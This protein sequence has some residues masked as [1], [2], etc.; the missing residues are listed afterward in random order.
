[1]QGEFRGDFTR[2][3]ASPDKSFLRVLMQAGRV[4]IDADWNEQV[5]NLLRYIQGLGQ[6]LIGFHGGREESFLIQPI[7]GNTDDFAITPGRYYVDGIPCE[8]KARQDP[9]GNFQNWTYN[10]QPYYSISEN[11]SL[12]QLHKGN[13][14]IALLVYL[15]MWER[16]ISFVEDY[17]P[18]NPGIRE[19]A[20]GGPDTATRSQVVWQIKVLPAQPVD[21]VLDEPSFEGDVPD[22][23]NGQTPLEILSMQMRLLTRESFRAYLQGSSV[24]VKP[25]TGKLKARVKNTQE[26][27]D[28]CRI[29]SKSKYRG[30]ENRLYR[31]EIMTPRDQKTTYAWA[32]SNSSDKFPIRQAAGEEDT[33]TVFLEHLGQDPRHS[34]TEEDWVEFVNDPWVLGDEPRSLFRI[35]SIDIH[36]R[37]VMLKKPAGF[38]M[39]SLDS[40]NS[41]EHHPY[42]RRWDSPGGVDISFSAEINDGWLAVEDGIEIQFVDFEQAP[43]QYKTGDYWIIPARTATG[44]IEWPKTLNMSDNTLVPKALAPKGIDHYYAPLALLEVSEQEAGKTVLETEDCRRLLKTLWE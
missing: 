44:D 16:H 7:N 33:V 15:D 41:P 19:V 5:D 4:Q 40:F 10:T 43:Q 22:G 26:S 21:E 32:R 13:S 17:D 9:N 35:E 24:D 20:L 18:A 11:N 38:Q 36:E 30:L 31:V 12:E 28:P 39:F 37:S 29:S 1:M 3:T 2:D 8:Q 34:L 25:G 14:D 42:L 27:E 6:D 23:S